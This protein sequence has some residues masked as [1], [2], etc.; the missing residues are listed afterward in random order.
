MKSITHRYRENLKL[1]IFDLP[2][3]IDYT[4]EDLRP[5]LSEAIR[6]TIGRPVTMDRI[7][8]EENCS[9]VLLDVYKRELDRFPSTEEFQAIKD[10]FN[11]RLRLHF[12]TRDNLYDVQHGVQNILMQLQASPEW[13]FCVVSDYWAEATN[14]MLDSCGIYRKNIELYSADDGLSSQD[15]INKITARRYLSKSAKEVY[16]ISRQSHL[17][18]QLKNPVHFISLK[19]L[20][21]ST[22]NY[23]SYPKFADIF[24]QPVKAG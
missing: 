5:L 14:F 15:I 17:S 18:I 9:G 16:L 24:R 1:V 13:H 19:S 22:L 23:F 2:A 6:E 12:M 3:V 20:R 11:N 10:N 8:W 7:S 4:Q 21:R